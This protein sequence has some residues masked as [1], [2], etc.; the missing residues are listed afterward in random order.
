LSKFNVKVHN[1][2]NQ[3][4][5]E[6]V[7]EKKISAWNGRFSHNDS[8]WDKLSQFERSTLLE[9]LKVNKS[10]FVTA[11]DTPKV[12]DHLVAFD[13]TVVAN[14]DWLELESELEYPSFATFSLAAKATVFLRATTPDS[15]RHSLILAKHDNDTYEYIKGVFSQNTRIS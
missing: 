15:L 3:D 4:L 6:L 11:K 7:G 14:K 13:G 8:E 2:P 10:F 9:H 1:E 5:Y 12:F